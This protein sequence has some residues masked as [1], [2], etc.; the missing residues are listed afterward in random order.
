MHDVHAIVDT[1]TDHQGH[2]HQVGEVVGQAKKA[3]G[4]QHPQDPHAQGKC[5]QQGVAQAA[6]VQV[7]HQQDQQPPSHHRLPETVGDTPGHALKDHRE[8]G[9]LRADATGCGH[10][11]LQEGGLE[12]IAGR[13]QEGQQTAVSGQVAPPHG[14]RQVIRLQGWLVGG[15]AEAGQGLP[16]PVQHRGLGRLPGGHL[17]RAGGLG[18]AP[19]LSGGRTGILQGQGQKREPGGEGVFGGICQDLFQVPQGAC[20]LRR[21]HRF[22]C[23]GQAQAGKLLRQAPAGLRRCALRVGEQGQQRIEVADAGLLFS[24]GGHEFEGVAVPG[25]DD[26]EEG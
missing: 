13:L 16:G 3:H 18:K 24:P 1:D 4:T 21:R 8:A 19:S 11:A 14:L 9:G 20:Q 17:L 10:V 7:E 22:Q 2:G 26:V 15:G 12:H 25:A 23:G 6:G 5:R